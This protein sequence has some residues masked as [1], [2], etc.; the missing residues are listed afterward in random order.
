MKSILIKNGTI[1][2]GERYLQGSV[3]LRDGKVEAVGACLGFRA[4]FEFDAAGALVCPGLVD[5]HT[6]LKGLGADIYGVLPEPSC[7]PFG[8]T[9]AVEAGGEKTER[10]EDAFH[11]KTAIFASVW[12]VDGKPTFEQAERVIRAHGDR[13]AGIK[14]CYDKGQVDVR[15]VEPFRQVCDF[16]HSRGYR[17]MVHCTDSPVPLGEL[18]ACMREGDIC[19]HVYHGIGHTAAEDGFR[20]L[21]EARARG[22]LLD[23]G[24]AG[25]VHCSYDIARAALAAGLGPDTVSTDITRFSA[26][27]RG[28]NYGM[29]W[30]MSVMRYLGMREEAVLRAVTADAARA[31]GRQDEW[32]RLLPGRAADVAVL[33]YGPVHI[34]S[35]DRNGRRIQVH[36]GYRCLFTV[37]DGWMAYRRDD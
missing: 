22:I 8:V 37:A 19:T 10:A 32:G 4:D 34:D 33:K 3:A 29:T 13:I 26:F 12:Y 18:L 7:Y 2:D 30:A 31:V 15:S 16:A 11:L 17:L 28:G 25:G 14:T 27:H 23:T 21:R 9:A 36:E 24:L 20:A 35:T 5:I 1:W 6:H